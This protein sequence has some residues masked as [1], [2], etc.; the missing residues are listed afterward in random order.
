MPYPEIVRQFVAGTEDEV[1]QLL[2]DAVIHFR[3][4]LP[5]TRAHPPPVTGHHDRRWVWMK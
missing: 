2:T 4:P 1:S 3:V 5:T